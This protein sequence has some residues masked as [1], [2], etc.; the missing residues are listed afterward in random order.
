MFAEAQVLEFAPRLK[1]LEAEEP[2]VC[3]WRSMGG[4]NS[5]RPA[6]WRR[7]GRRMRE[8]L[9]LTRSLPRPEPGQVVVVAIHGMRPSSAGNLRPVLAE[10]KRRGAPAFLVV[11][12][13]TSGLLDERLH[14]G[15]ADVALLQASIGHVRSRVHRRRA[16]ELANELKSVLTGGLDGGS[17]TWL[18]AG[19]ATREAARTWL[20]DAGPV[21]L[22]TDLSSKAKGLALAANEA[23]GASVVLQH[24]MIGPREFPVHARSMF[25]W[26]SWFCEQARRMGAPGEQPLAVGCPRMD[27]LA[28]VREEPRDPSLRSRLFGDVSAPGVLVISTAHAAPRSPEIYQAALE[29]IRRLLEAGFTLALKLHPGERDDSWYTRNLPDRLAEMVRV[30][31]PEIGIHH[32]IHHADVAFHVY[33]AAAMEAMLLGCP[34]LTQQ[35]PRPDLELTDLPDQGGGSWV[36]AGNIVEC[37]RG[38]ARNGALRQGILERQEALL[39]R[40]FANRGGAASAVVDLLLA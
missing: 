6:L 15:H 12:R 4:E 21:V 18:E 40:A 39:D 9:D 35:A 26:G 29:S 25:C 13:S 22:P 7:A 5:Q 32:A 20:C 19:L 10:L 36:D 14:Q 31:P 1:A 30:V 34:V 27:P 28:G 2:L 3:C 11:N 38:V 17:E 8:I 33:S 23:G 24:G 16:H 37:V